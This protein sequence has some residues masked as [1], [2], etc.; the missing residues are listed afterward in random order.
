MVGRNDVRVRVASGNSYGGYYYYS[1][2]LPRS[3]HR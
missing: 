3:A 2:I 1:Y